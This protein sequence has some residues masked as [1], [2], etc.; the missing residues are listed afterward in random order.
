MPKVNI[1]QH[2]MAPNSLQITIAES[3][4][5]STLMGLESSHREQFQLCP[6]SKQPSPVKDHNI[7]LIVLYYMKRPQN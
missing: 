6:S 4:L 1:K 5:H 7:N 3:L 2:G